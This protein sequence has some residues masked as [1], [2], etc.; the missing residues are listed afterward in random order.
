MNPPR[1]NDGADRLDDDHPFHNLAPASDDVSV[2]SNALEKNNIPGGTE[3][4]CLKGVQ[5][6]PTIENEGGRREALMSTKALSDISSTPSDVSKVSRLRKVRHV[7]LYVGDA[8][9]ARG[10]GSLPRSMQLR[11]LI[12]RVSYTVRD[13]PPR[14]FFYVHHQ[15]LNSF[16]AVP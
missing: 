12:D 16:T 11:I 5:S 4:P 10:D 1:A 13:A 2:E 9:H 8:G 7:S 6:P 14:R 3:R 15:N